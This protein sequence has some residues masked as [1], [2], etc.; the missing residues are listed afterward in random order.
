MFLDS[1]RCDKWLGYL[2]SD[3]RQIQLLLEQ[4]LYP[5]S[6]ISKGRFTST[7]NLMRERCVTRKR[8]S[9]R[10]GKISYQATVPCRRSLSV[11]AGRLSPTPIIHVTLLLFVDRVIYYERAHQ[12]KGRF[13]L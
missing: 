2:L 12:T 9:K 8:S 11:S 6:R 4:C 1:N 13:G 5:P 10:Y 3:Q 7:S